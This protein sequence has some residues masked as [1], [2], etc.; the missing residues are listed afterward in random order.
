MKRLIS[1]QRLDCEGHMAVISSS[2]K[3]VYFLLFAILAVNI[4]IWLNLKQQEQGLQSFIQKQGILK[5][6]QPPPKLPEANLD[7]TILKKRAAEVMQKL[8][9]PPSNNKEFY[10]IFIPEVLCPKIIRVGECGDG[11]KFV[12]NPPAIPK[13]CVI[14]SLGLNNQIMFDVDIQKRSQNKCRILGADLSEQNA[15]TKE[16]YQKMRGT[17]FVGAI[18]R[19]LSVSEIMRKSS[20]SEAE[21]LKMDIEHAEHHALEPFLK[22]YK[23]CQIFLEIHGAPAL[24]MSLLKKISK[25]GYRIFSVEPNIYCPLCCEYKKYSKIGPFFPFA[26]A[27]QSGLSEADVLIGKS[28][29]KKTVVHIDI[30]Y[31]FKNIIQQE[32]FD[33]VWIDVESAEYDILPFF[34]RG[35]KFDLNKITICQF[36]IEMKHIRM[37]FVN[38]A[39]E[40]CVKKYIS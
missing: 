34:Y 4:F 1:S 16:T 25:Q 35:G 37:F 11:G 38:F 36:N 12:C 31:F 18:G 30:I 21:L 15:K 19:T 26:V 24:H 9:N 2:S 20:A 17:L 13:D 6:D 29:K 7:M 22:E 27:A 33:N 14:V 3:N 39:D 28:Y 40:R 32:F 5:D 8:R 23:V 10:D